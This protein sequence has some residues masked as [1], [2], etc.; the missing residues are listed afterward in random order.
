MST[1]DLT[2]S[3]EN[4]SFHGSLPLD[5]RRQLAQIRRAAFLLYQ[6][7]PLTFVISRLQVHV[8]VGVVFLFC[9]HVY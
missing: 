5:S 6:S 2:N 7:Q 1:M 3:S 4:H 8:H 9:V